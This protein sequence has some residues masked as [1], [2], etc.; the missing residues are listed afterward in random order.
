MKT[1][2]IKAV[3]CT[4]ASN[5]IQFADASGK[6]AIMLDSGYF[7]ASQAECDRVAQAGVS[8]AYLADHEGQIMTVPIN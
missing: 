4:T 5:A 8:F 1:M 2:Q 6:S 3:K 7:A